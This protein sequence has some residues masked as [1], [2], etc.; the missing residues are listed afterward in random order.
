MRS[1][2]GNEQTVPLCKL[3]EIYIFPVSYIRMVTNENVPLKNAFNFVLACSETNLN[4]TVD[5]YKS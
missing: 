1:I 5:R 3:T 2:L 4:M